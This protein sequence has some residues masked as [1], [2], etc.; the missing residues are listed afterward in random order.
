M[1]TAHSQRPATRPVRTTP[2]A[3]AIA[4]QVL[5]QLDPLYGPVAWN[6]RFNA[7]DELIFTV[8]SQHTSDVNSGAAYRSLRARF[9]SWLDLIEA[10]PAEVADAIRQGGLANQKAPRI[11]EILRIVLER[12]GAFDLEFLAGLPVDEARVWLDSLP[13]I[14]K[15]STAIVLNFALGMPAMPVD[16]HIYRVGRRLGLVPF[17]ASV[18]RAH[19]IMEAQVAPE[20]IFR[21]HVLLITHGR[22]VCRAQRPACADCA[23]AAVCPSAAVFERATGASGRGRKYRRPV[24]G[25]QLL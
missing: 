25:G 1:G 16:T 11:Q 20:D 12:T 7:L 19:D 15:K 23:L 4:A 8:L 10:G 21:Y 14:G 5:E 13:G 17:K 9:P 3:K 2:R 22:R 24:R 6:P 18:D